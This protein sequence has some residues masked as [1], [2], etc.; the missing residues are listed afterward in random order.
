M[1]SPDF[2]DGGLDVAEQASVASREWQQALQG[3]ASALLCLV[4]LAN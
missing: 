4:R 1:A 2:F 3:D